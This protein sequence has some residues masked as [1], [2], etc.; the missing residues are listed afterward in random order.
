[1]RRVYVDTGA[2]IALISRRDQDH[3]RVVRHFRSL[4]ANRDVL[5]ASDPAIGETVT[6]LRYDAGLA[7]VARFRDVLERSVA[8]GSLQVH[9]SNP[10]LRADALRQMERFDGLALSY[11]DA[12]GAVV[13]RRVR[14]DVVFALDHDFRVMGFSVEP[15]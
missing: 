6:R 13:A 11:A 4:R 12:V 15:S 2:F 3:E 8:R 14:A 1:M 9:E 10:E 5:F 7:A